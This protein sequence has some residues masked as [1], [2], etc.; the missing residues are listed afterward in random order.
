M[1]QGCKHLHLEV[2]P[3]LNGVGYVHDVFLPPEYLRDWVLEERG[4]WSE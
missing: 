1:K 2:L 4:L 3:K